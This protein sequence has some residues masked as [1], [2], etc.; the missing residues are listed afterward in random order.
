LGRF[1]K[2]QKFWTLIPGHPLA[3]FGNEIAFERR[4]RN[5]KHRRAAQT[6][7]ELIEVVADFLKPLAPVIDQIHL[8]DR[9]NEVPDAEKMRDERMPAGLRHHAVSRVDQDDGEIAVAGAGNQVSR[10]L[11]VAWSIGN[12]ELPL[13]RSE[14]TIGHIDGDALFAFCLQ[15]VGQQGKIDAF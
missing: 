11:F 13:W 4:Y 5:A 3:R 15:S 2:V 8:V 10:V 14:V 7:D 1:E 9:N 6:V 12:N